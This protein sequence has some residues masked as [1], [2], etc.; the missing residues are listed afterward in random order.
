MSARCSAWSSPRRSPAYRAVAQSAVAWA[1]QPLEHRL[2]LLG[3]GEPRLAAVDR[4]DADAARRVRVDLAELAGATVHRAQRS[5]GGRD[6]RRGETVRGQAVD[7]PLQPRKRE[8]AQTLVAELV[9]DVQPQD[10]FVPPNRGGLAR[11][12]R[13]RADDPGARGGEP[14]VGG[15]RERRPAVGAERPSADG[16]V[17]VLSPAAGGRDRRERLV[18]R[19][20]RGRV[21]DLRLERRR[22]GA[23]CLA[24]A[25]APSVARRDAGLGATVLR[26][27]G[28]PVVVG[29]GP[30]RSSVAGPL[31][32]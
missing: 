31:S 13:P 20:A 19:L 28:G 17:C 25:A 30:G 9:E 15:V 1:V 8:L 4:R 32:R 7:E 18:D 29:H 11:I 23:T 27:H 16:G 5:D 10:L 26:A 6:R 12:A 2:D 21:V 14:L 3:G 22:A 24:V